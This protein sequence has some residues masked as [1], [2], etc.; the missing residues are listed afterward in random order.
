MKIF[1]LLLFYCALSINTIAQTLPNQWFP[2]TGTNTYTVA[3]ITNFG[4]S[5]TN[6]VCHIKFQN[7]NTG[8]STINISNNGNPIGA[9]PIRAWDGDSWEPVTAGQIDSD[10]IYRLS[11]SPSNYFQ[12][13]PIGTGGGA[14]G[15][16]IG[17]TTITNGSNGD[18]LINNSGTLS[19]IATTGTGNLARVNSPLFVTPNIGSATGSISGNAGT[20]TALQT[21]RTING[22]SFDGTGNITV[23][24]A[25][26]TLTG[27]TLNATVVTSSLTSVG[28]LTNLTVTNPITGSTTGNAGKYLTHNVQT[29]NYTLVLTDA[30]TKS[31]IMR[32]VSAQ[33]LTVPPN[34]SVA[35]P[36]GTTIIV[37]PDST[38]VTTV[39]AGSGVTIE[40]SAGVLTS[41]CQDCP[42]VLEK[43]NGANIWFLRNGSPAPGTLSVIGG[44][45][46]NSSLTAYAPLFGG[47]TSTGAIQ[48]G[49]VGTSG[50]VLTSNGAGV[51]ATFQTL[52]VF[53]SSTYTP[54]LTNTANIAASTARLCT[55]LRLGST[56]TVSGQLDIDPTTTLTTTTLGISLPV[57]SSLTTAFQ[58]GGTAAASTVSDNAAAIFSDATNDRATLQYT[59][60][61][62]TNHTMTFTF[63][64][65]VL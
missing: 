45:T 40:S 4:S 64:Y 5:Y 62:V 9:A 57:S 18:V 6:K 32:S 58:L 10:I 1:N 17:T 27:T 43:K 49:A 50:Q 65:Q 41:P 56:V 11:Y 42:M 44:G 12:L 26:G 33:N 51:I 20:A 21:A 19:G 34:N 31:I 37:T 61:D 23:T 46:G 14:S 30:D 48:S 15:L 13:E 59:C 3:S 39:V 55:Y 35:F 36:E 2:A 54:T 22:T 52:P 53:A 7:D 28:T 47:T 24:A 60:V 16:D 25:A 63:T 8:A 38:G 29:G